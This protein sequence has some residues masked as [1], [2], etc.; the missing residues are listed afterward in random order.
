MAAM[1]DMNN[2]STKNKNLTI[3]KPCRLQLKINKT[4]KFSDLINYT[5]L[6]DIHCTLKDG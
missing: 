6:I 1:N 3:T 5:V 2:M 4:K